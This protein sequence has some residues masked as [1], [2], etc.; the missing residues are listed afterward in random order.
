[1]KEIHLLILKHLSEEEEL[2]QTVSRIEVLVGVIFAFSLYLSSARGHI[3]ALYHPCSPTRTSGNSQPT[4]GMPLEHLAL[5]ARG[6]YVSGPHRSKII[7]E[8]VIGRLLQISYLFT[9][10]LLLRGTL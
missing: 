2:I 7:E 10:E 9:L 8:K 5:M 4:Q 1:M 6:S 3:L